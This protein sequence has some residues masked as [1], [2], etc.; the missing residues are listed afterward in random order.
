MGWVAKII[1]GVGWLLG[2]LY[3][4]A[5]S[6]QY[7]HDF[8]LPRYQQHRLAY[9]M[10]DQQTCGKHVANAYCQKLGYVAAQ[11]MTIDYN[12]GYTRFLDKDRLCKGW[13]CHGFKLIRC[14]AQA[15]HQPAR[16]YHY[17]YKQFV[18]PRVRHYRVAWCY[19]H[20]RLCGKRAAYAFCRY[21][22]YEEATNYQP[23]A[24]LAATRSL[25]DQK[26]CF[27]NCQGFASI[28]CHR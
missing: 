20:N 7:T 11:R 13:A 14:Y 22:E 2:S 1:I 21:M 24:H 18:L 28:T 26:L 4:H 3:A 10:V 12:V 19:R 23:A 15:S 16:G 27:G 5:D 17:R 9:C 25:S 6:T 8:W